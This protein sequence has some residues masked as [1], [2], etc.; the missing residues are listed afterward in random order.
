MIIDEKCF[1]RYTQCTLKLRSFKL[2][3]YLVTRIFRH[4]FLGTDFAV[5]QFFMPKII[6]FHINWLFSRHFKAVSIDKDIEPREK[7]D[8]SQKNFPFE[9]FVVML[10]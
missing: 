10:T 3:F 1:V 5:S 7:F 4:A 9:I 6:G 8:I 2:R